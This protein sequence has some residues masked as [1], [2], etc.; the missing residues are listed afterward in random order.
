MKI[1]SF[2]ECNTIFAKDQSEYLRLPAHKTND[3]E[4]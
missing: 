3:G 2:K 4:L 1:V